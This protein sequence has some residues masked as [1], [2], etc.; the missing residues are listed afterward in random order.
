MLLLSLDWPHYPCP[1]GILFDGCNINPSA[2]AFSC[3]PVASLHTDFLRLLADPLGFKDPPVGLS[4]AE[5]FHRWLDMLAAPA[6]F[7]CSMRPALSPMTPSQP[8][9][10]TCSTPCTIDT[11]T[12][13]GSMDASVASV[14]LGSPVESPQPLPRFRISCCSP[15]VSGAPDQVSDDEV[16]ISHLHVATPPQGPRGVAGTSTAGSSYSGCLKPYCSDF[17]L[18]MLLLLSRTQVF[19]TFPPPPPCLWLS[20]NLHPP[21]G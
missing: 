7:L 8:P 13:L 5:H 21:A 20:L 3:T 15:P 12:T 10:R 17:V 2:P 18:V 16:P 14:L 4:V 6:C 9:P 11:C 1:L 19:F